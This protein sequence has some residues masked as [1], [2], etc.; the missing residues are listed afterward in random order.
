MGYLGSLISQQL[1]TNFVIFFCIIEQK[2]TVK[3]DKERQQVVTFK[4]E[5][6]TFLLTETNNPTINN[7]N[8]WQL[9]VQ[10]INLLIAAT[11]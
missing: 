4:M 7:Q 3:N 6:L 8:S 11:Q 10:L 5:C 9:I 2:P 1:V